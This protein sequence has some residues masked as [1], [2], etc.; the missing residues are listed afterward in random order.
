M[1][2]DPVFV[3]ASSGIR[4]METEPHKNARKIINLRHETV[5]ARI[6]Q[7]K[8]LT[9]RFRHDILKHSSCF[10]ACAVLTQLSFKYDKSPFSV[11]DALDL[12]GYK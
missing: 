2:E 12:A 3:K 6:K 10:R 4:F 5:N 8:V 7:F 9:D 1:G 11:T